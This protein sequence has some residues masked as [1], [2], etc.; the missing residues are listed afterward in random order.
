MLLK[1]YLK[2]TRQA[3]TFAEDGECAVDLFVANPYDL[4]FM[5]M[6]M[7]GMDGLAATRAIRAIERTEGRK[8]TPI[9]A[10]TANSLTQDLAASQS[11]G[12]D[13]H[14]SKP[15][16][17][18][19]LLS[20]I[21]QYR[22]PREPRQSIPPVFVTIPIGLEELV[23]EY[24]AGRRKELPVLERSLQARDFDHI[25]RLAHDLKGTG[26]SFGFPDLTEMG[27]ALELSAADGSVSMLTRQ[28]ADLGVY[29][30]SVQL[31]GG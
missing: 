23:P 26:A 10:I 14:L 30:G 15:I 17:K 7:P 1:A 4:I 2:Q 29:L 16:S 31:K 5:D 25:R 18:E 9:V 20:A 27:R 11:A 3:L 6:Q 24:L 21:E 28:L 22:R 19:K 12:C 13:A 8:A